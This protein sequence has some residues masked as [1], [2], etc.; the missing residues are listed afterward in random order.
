MSDRSPID[1]ESPFSTSPVTTPTKSKATD[2]YEN[3]SLEDLDPFS[4]S[5]NQ[6][7]QQQTHGTNGHHQEEEQQ[8]QQHSNGNHDEHENGIDLLSN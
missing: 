5:N 4:H 6:Q 1:Q 3:R 8:Q 2:L 7:Q